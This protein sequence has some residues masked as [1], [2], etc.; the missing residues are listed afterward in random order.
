MMAKSVHITIQRCGGIYQSHGADATPSWEQLILCP[1]R[2]NN[3]ENQE[4]LNTHADQPSESLDRRS[5]GECY[6]FALQQYH[7]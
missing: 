4:F 6:G 2:K 7:K 1:H 5:R 3:P